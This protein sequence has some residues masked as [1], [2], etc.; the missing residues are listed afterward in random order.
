MNLTI[1]KNE[2]IIANFSSDIN[3]SR[4]GNFCDK[5]EIIL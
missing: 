2:V 3:K 4:T 1:Y 5:N